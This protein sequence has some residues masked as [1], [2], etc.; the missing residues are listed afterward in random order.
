MQ[1]AVQVVRA[2]AELVVGAACDELL[3]KAHHESAGSID[4]RAS[5][6]SDPIPE[7]D[8]PRKANL[9]IP[10]KPAL[11]VPKKPDMDVSKKPDLAIPKR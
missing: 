9:D 2:R 3:V 11:D 7:L 8:A 5:P 10:K 1:T 4:R 6:A